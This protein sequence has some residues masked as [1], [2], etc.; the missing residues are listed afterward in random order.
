M[1]KPVRALGAN[2][3]YGYSGA[4]TPKAVEVEGLGLA[5]TTTT[6]QADGQLTQTSANVE[7]TVFLGSNQAGSC[8]PGELVTNIMEYGNSISATA[9]P[10]NVT[11]STR[12]T[13]WTIGDRTV[14]WNPFL[15]TSTLDLTKVGGSGIGIY[16]DETAS[17]WSITRPGMYLVQLNRGGG[18]AVQVYSS[19][20]IWAEDV[21]DGSRLFG[22]DQTAGFVRNGITVGVQ[23]IGIV[24]GP[25]TFRLRYSSVLSTSESFD[26]VTVMIRRIQ[27]QAS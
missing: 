23:A 10:I 15:G 9:E 20:Q 11:S 26:Y 14:E 13:K 16:F 18:E 4:A 8:A 7:N 1:S 19:Q 2:V 21:S 3:F 5:A 27:S 22:A 24:K 6:T 25:L 17:T 12:P